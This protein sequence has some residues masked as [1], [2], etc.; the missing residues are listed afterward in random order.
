MRKLLPV[1]AGNDDDDDDD[2]DEDNDD[3]GNDNSVG[4]L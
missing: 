3:I 4:I 1:Q 2:D